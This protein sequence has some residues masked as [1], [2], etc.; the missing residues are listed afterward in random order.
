[1]ADLA[2]AQDPPQPRHHVVR[3]EPGGLVDDHETGQIPRDPEPPCTH[4]PR[5]RRS[6]RARRPPPPSGPSAPAA[7]PR[8]GGCTTNA[9]RPVQT[10]TSPQPNT[11]DA[12]VSGRKPAAAATSVQV[13]RYAASPAPS[14][15]PSRANTTPVSGCIPAKNHQAAGIAAST[16]GSRGEQRAAGPRPARRTAAR[17]R[18]RAP[19]RSR[20][21]AGPAPGPARTSPLPSAAP[22]SDCAA[23]ATA[24]STSAMKNHSCRTTWCAATDAAPNR[25]ATAA[26][27]RKQ[28]WKARLRASRSRPMASC[29]RS[30]TGTGRSDTGSGA[31]A[32]ARSRCSACRNSPAPTAWPARLAAADPTRPSPPTPP[33][34]CTSGTHS[35]ADRPLPAST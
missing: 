9:V 30:S 27:D 3:G 5:G 8:P 17:S 18:S 21:P 10:P 14:S 12:Q 31:A 35:T 19:A 34:P 6:G 33:R 25:A 26:A 20:R 22:T 7:A 24:S 16:A 2:G 1:M 29:A 28:A 32:T 15:T 23:I 11:S 4:P 13:R